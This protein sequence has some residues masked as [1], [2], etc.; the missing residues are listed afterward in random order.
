LGLKGQGLFAAIFFGG[1]ILFFVFAHLA[2]V[3]HSSGDP[4]FGKYKN[5][6]KQPYDND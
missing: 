1:F 5:L 4:Q 2:T 6:Q 3:A